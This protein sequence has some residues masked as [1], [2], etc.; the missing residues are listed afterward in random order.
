VSLAARFG[1]QEWI[2][3]RGSFRSR[4]GRFRSFISQIK[5]FFDIQLRKILNAG[6]LLDFRY[7]GRVQNIVKERLTRKIFPN[8]GFANH[9][10]SLCSLCRPESRSGAQQRSTLWCS[11]SPCYCELTVGRVKVVRHNLT[12]IFCGGL[13]KT[14]DGLRGAGTW[15]ELRFG[16]PG[17]VWVCGLG[18]GKNDLLPIGF[19]RKRSEVWPHRCSQVT[20]HPRNSRPA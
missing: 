7:G 15:C 2:R 20:T 11:C 5:F 12:R 18:L 8:K 9:F 3:V 6:G 17:L 13:W 19:Y 16:F 14:S 4:L 10:E 1:R